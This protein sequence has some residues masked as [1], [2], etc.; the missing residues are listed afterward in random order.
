MSL[1]NLISFIDN[2]KKKKIKYIIITHKKNSDLDNLKINYRIVNLTTWDYI[3]IFLNN[4][5]FIKKILKFL[6]IN[7]SFERKLFG[8]KV[9]LL[10]F[11]FVSWKSFLLNSV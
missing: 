6:N 1:N 11:F 7:S 10:I 4:L 9:K 3:F 2:F 5:F 8:L